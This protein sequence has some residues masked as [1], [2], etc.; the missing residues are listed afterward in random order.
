VPGN[1]GALLKGVGVQSPPTGGIRID[2]SEQWMD[3]HILKQQGL[4]IRK[5]AVLRGVSR[6][7]VR[8]AL[9]RSAPPTGK[10][11]RAKGVQLEN[12][13]SQI[14]AW[15]RDE[16]TGLWTAER[17]FDELQ[18]R[19]Y[20]GGRTVVKE[21]VRENRPRP[22]AMAE[23]RF[24]VKPGQQLQVD[25]ADM[26][27]V[28]IAGVQRKIYAFVAIMAWSRSLF[29]CCTTDMQ[30][31]TWLDCHRRAF[32]FFGGVPSEVLI[33]NLKTGVLSR[34]GGTIR[35][36]PSYEAL[37]VGFGFRPLAH[38]PM[39]PKTK[40]R[41]E[42]IVRFVRQ[43]FFAGRDSIPD[44]ESFNVEALRWLQERAN[45][46]VHRVTRERPCDRFTIEREA[47]QPLRE[48]DVVLETTR[49]CDSYGLVSVNGVRYSVP[50][51]HAREK[52][53]LQCRPNDLRFI[54]DGKIVAQHV[55]P[56][57]GV[58]L[59]QDPLHLPPPPSPR[60]ERFAQLGDT[61]AARF[62]QSGRRYVE[63]VERHA[64]HAP[65]ALLRE[66]LAR[67]D[68]Y[69]VNV[70]SLALESLLQFSVVKRGILTNL[71]HR[72]GGTPN[73]AAPISRPLPHIE[74]EQRSL[75]VYDEAAA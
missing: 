11:L 4:S 55:Y 27:V 69:G 6:N 20:G 26:G 12:Y 15:L 65:L 71:C 47:L 8:R 34:A 42:R 54:I 17:I 5:I 14:S 43:R 10:R 49:I 75:A 40:G 21:Y 53:L 24:Y 72:F 66:V 35:W 33:D 31:L 59:V 50:A 74:V 46:R 64:P 25:W 9:R 52:I 37:A 48:Y 63:A 41:V 58:H 16:V 23:A 36:H 68:E 19:G 18:D 22:R 2:R 44:I 51:E 60:H 29:V 13:K 1:G 70:V 57:H 73:I 30:L 45:K 67:H 39:R 56:A 3:F 62:G 28:S 7:A 61:I 32:A 38:F